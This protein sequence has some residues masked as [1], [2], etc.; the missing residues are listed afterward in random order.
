MGVVTL[1][2]GV[3][4]AVF[5]FS[6][7][8]NNQTAGEI[9]GEFDVLGTS[10]DALSR[11]VLTASWGRLEAPCFRLEHVLERVGALLKHLGGVLRCLGS[12]FRRLGDVFGLSKTI[13]PLY[14]S[15]ENHASALFAFETIP[16]SVL[17]AYRTVLLASLTR[18][19]EH[20]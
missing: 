4:G 17:V 8:Y 5:F 14:I 13:I 9:A 1:K 2:E 12:V 19:G 11:Q 20:S 18:L 6:P 10:S 16:N 7:L 15:F 3:A